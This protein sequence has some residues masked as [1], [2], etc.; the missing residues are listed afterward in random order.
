MKSPFLQSL[1]D[2]GVGLLVAMVITTVGSSMQSP[3]ARMG[4]R[5]ILIMGL[6]CAV[7]IAVVGLPISYLTKRLF[8]QSATTISPLI[9]G[10]IGFILSQAILFL[11]TLVFVSMHSGNAL[12]STIQ[13]L[14]VGEW[15][16]LT[17]GFAATGS[18]IGALSLINKESEQ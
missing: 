14:Y 4:V 18:V 15:R 13:M 16:S 10:V 8:A 1:K 12:E 17:A 9:F 3:Q 2:C 5:E 7:V 11:I 6:C